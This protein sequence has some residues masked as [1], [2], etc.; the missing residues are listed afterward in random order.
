M[1]SMPSKVAFL[2][3]KLLR[4]NANDSDNRCT[5]L[6]FLDYCDNIR[7]NPVCVALTKETKGIAFT[8]H[9]VGIC[10]Q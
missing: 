7:N 6:G 8:V 10:A 2:L 5:C 1:Y 4:I 9:A 3:L